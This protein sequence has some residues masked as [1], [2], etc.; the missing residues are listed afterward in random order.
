MLAKKKSIRIINKKPRKPA[1][2]IIHNTLAGEIYTLNYAIY[3][4]RK[5]IEISNLRNNTLYKAGKTNALNLIE[6]SKHI[7]ELKKIAKTHKIK[8]FIMDTWIFKEYPKLIEYFCKKYNLEDYNSKLIKLNL[9]LNRELFE[10]KIGS[11]Y[12]DDDYSIYVFKIK[13]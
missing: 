4:E 5:Y 12:F 2:E 7:I 3:P 9:R 11:R 1:E 6:F 8:Y 13:D 10:S